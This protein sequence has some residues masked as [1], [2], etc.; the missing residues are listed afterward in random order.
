MKPTHVTLR[1]WYRLLAA[2]PFS[3]AIAGC[4]T[5][6]H[7]PL[8]TIDTLPVVEVGGHLPEGGDYVLHYPKGYILPVILSVDGGLFAGER[9]TASTATLGRDLYLYKHW[10]SHDGKAWQ[11]S[12]DLI[13]VRITG[14]FD[15]EGLKVDVELGAR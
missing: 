1:P 10:A 4:A 8:A 6:G 14:G 7:V 12:H 13:D 15:A 2:L 9:T 3:L 5:S 11:N